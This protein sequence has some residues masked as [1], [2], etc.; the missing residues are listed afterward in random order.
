[1]R[2]PVEKLQ[3]GGQSLTSGVC[4]T[5][6]STERPVVPAQLHHVLYRNA[7]Y[8]NRYL[9]CEMQ[10]RGNTVLYHLFYQSKYRLVILKPR[11]PEIKRNDLRYQI[12]QRYSLTKPKTCLEKYI[13]D[14]LLSFLLLTTLQLP[15]NKMQA[16]CGATIS[17]EPRKWTTTPLYLVHCLC[18]M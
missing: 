2:S 10:I 17:T 3:Q 18:S 16:D 6:F 11:I 12:Y 14:A 1:M 7:N 8:A 9:F 4:I 5:W 15:V 13:N